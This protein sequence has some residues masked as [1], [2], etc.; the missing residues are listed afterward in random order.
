MRYKIKTETFYDRILGVFRN[1]T[2][3]RKMCLRVGDDT[4]LRKN[5]SQ[6]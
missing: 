4:W 5:V 2:Y 1:S 6:K 3:G